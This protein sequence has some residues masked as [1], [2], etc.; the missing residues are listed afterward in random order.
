MQAMREEMLRVVTLQIPVRGP[1]NEQHLLLL[2]KAKRDGLENNLKAQI[3]DCLN[4]PSGV[5]AKKSQDAALFQWET[6]HTAHTR[7]TSRQTFDP[8]M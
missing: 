6:H 4:I 7:V 1:M 2:S 5:H 3:C 8:V